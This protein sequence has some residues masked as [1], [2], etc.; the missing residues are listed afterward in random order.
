MI[1]NYRYEFKA[2]KGSKM[3]K[4]ITSQVI[5]IIAEKFGKSPADIVENANFIEDLGADSLDTTEL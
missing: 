2:E 3:S 1:G 4:E 5:E